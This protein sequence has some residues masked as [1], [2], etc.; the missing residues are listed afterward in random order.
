MTVLQ[1]YSS[2]VCDTVTILHITKKRITLPLQLTDDLNPN[3]ED[4]YRWATCCIILQVKL[5]A[6]DNDCDRLDFQ[7]SN[8]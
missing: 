1:R 2:H 8:W 6:C 7:S 4:A 5:K 3:F